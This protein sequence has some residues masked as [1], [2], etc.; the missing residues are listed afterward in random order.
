MKL[1]NDLWDCLTVPAGNHAFAYF[2]MVVLWMVVFIAAGFFFFGV[3][4]LADMISR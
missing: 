3:A 1:L 4:I 2:L